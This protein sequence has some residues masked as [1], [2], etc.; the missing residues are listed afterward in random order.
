MAGEAVGAVGAELQG[1]RALLERAEGDDATRSAALDALLER[2]MQV[3]TWPGSGEALRTLRNAKGEQALGLWSGEDTLVASA[4]QL[5]W[6]TAAGAL[7]MRRVEARE[8][9]EAALAQGVAFVVIDLGSEHALELA[10][11]ELSLL[12][13]VKQK[14]SPKAS[15]AAQRER[16]TASSKGKGLID[17]DLPFVHGR[18]EQ[19]RPEAVAEA[20][21]DMLARAFAAPLDDGPG[22]KETAQAAAP[23]QVA[24]PSPALA[25]QAHAHAQA[26]TSGTEAG[27]AKASSGAKARTMLGH[28]AP[29]PAPAPAPRPHAAEDKPAPSRAAAKPVAEEAKPSAIKSAARALATMIGSGDAGAAASAGSSAS[30]A[31]DASGDA[32]EPQVFAEGALRPLELGLSEAA[33]GAIA[34]ALRGYPEVEWACEVSDGSEVPVIGLRV[35]PQFVTRVAQVE[36]ATL[37]AGTA[38]GA[39]LR[40]L[41]LSEAAVMREARTHGRAFYPWKKRR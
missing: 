23:A 17:F 31:G 41:M 40:V 2:S 36:A 34:E 12:L 39:E 20:A 18:P 19:G 16:A 5:G 11:D 35:S 22:S 26:Q 1:F 38:R 6:H 15:S 32:D 3:A 33:L 29:A 8:A 14:R 21:P 10:G 24:A 13:A 7:P 27:G 30:S 9:I 28:A 37:A 4:L 25:A